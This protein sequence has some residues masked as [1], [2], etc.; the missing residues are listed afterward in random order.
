MQYKTSCLFYLSLFPIC[1]FSETPL[2][3]LSSNL[4]YPYPV[5]LDRSHIYLFRLSQVLVY[6]NPT[7]VNSVFPPFSTL[8][9]SR[10]VVSKVVW[11]QLR[12]TAKGSTGLQE[13]KYIRTLII[14][15]FSSHPFLNS[16]SVY[17]YK[18]HNILVQ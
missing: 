4:N 15:I 17:I 16:I 9:S 3:Y 13:K 6:L 18:L 10:K 1:L 8:P 12:E 7:K 2:C 5:P 11:L 14:L